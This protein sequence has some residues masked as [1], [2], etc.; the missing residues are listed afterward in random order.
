M[1]I[2]LLTCIQKILNV[3]FTCIQ[4]LA[5]YFKFI[6]APYICFGVGKFL[7]VL[8]LGKNVMFW[9]AINPVPNEIWN[10][11]DIERDNCV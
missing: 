2:K 9:T 3:R 8:Y 5:E 1:Y 7:S 10:V 6:L 11:L 4:F